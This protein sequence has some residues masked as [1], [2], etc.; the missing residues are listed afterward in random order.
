ML[1]LIWIFIL[2]KAFPYILLLMML[3]LDSYNTHDVRWMREN[4]EQ[5]AEVFHN[6]TD[7]FNNSIPDSLKNANTI[8][9]TVNNKDDCI[10]ITIVS[11]NV[12]DGKTARK[13]ASSRKQDAE[14]YDEILSDIGLT[15]SKAD[16]IRDMLQCINCDVIRTFPARNFD[17]EIYDTSQEDLPI[18]SSYLHL[19]DSVKSSEVVTL[20][21]ITNAK[22]ADR[23]AIG[24]N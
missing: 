11:H 18:F 17:V 8:F 21:K 1:P 24:T 13:E 7:L 19:R 12:I 14:K 22:Y 16:S 4:F 20:S 9:F 3:F 2:Y 23:F 10:E 15:T 6:V 5:N